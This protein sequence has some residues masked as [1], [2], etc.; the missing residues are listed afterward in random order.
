M[1]GGEGERGGESWG[2]GGGGQN[3]KRR[4]RRGRREVS[5]TQTGIWL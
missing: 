2:R 4:G 5:V 1:Y 3:S